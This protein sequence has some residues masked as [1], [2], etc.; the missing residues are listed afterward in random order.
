MY[1]D[2]LFNSVVSNIDSANSS[3]KTSAGGKVSQ[4]LFVVLPMFQSYMGKAICGCGNYSFGPLL[5]LLTCYKQPEVTKKK[6]KKRLVC[7]FVC[8]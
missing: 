2:T 8:L 4:V 7:L 3:Q 5:Q 6:R 1:E